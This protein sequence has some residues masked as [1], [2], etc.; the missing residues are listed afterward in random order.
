M[1]CISVADCRCSHSILEQ[2]HVSFVFR[3]DRAFVQFYFHFSNH[4]QTTVKYLYT[5]GALN[6][7]ICIV[8][9]VGTEI[10]D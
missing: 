10:C 6:V 3:V 4:H 1:L 5:S 9:A 8:Y 2:K 7:G